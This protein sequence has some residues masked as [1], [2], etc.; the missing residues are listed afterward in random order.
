MCR[1]ANA[2]FS[3]FFGCALR[4]ESP[5]VAWAPLRTPSNPE[6]FAI[7]NG[8]EVFTVNRL[9]VADYDL[10]W[11][12]IRMP[13]GRTPHNVLYSP[14]AWLYLVVRF[15]FGEGGV[16]QV[17]PPTSPFPN[18][19]TSKDE[20]FVRPVIPNVDGTPSEAVDQPNSA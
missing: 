10:P 8:R 3:I 11:P 19:V 15:E 4:V 14:E 17:R 1:N 5:V 13:L 20:P 6:G 7:L 16:S 18:Q 2:L 9:P 12:A